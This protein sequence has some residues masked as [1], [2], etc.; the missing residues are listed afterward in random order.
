MYN[1]IK[2]FFDATSCDSWCEKASNIL[3]FYI[4]RYQKRPR[5]HRNPDANFFYVTDI[6]DQ[7]PWLE[8][9]NLYICMYMYFIYINI[10]INIYVLYM[11]AVLTPKIDFPDPKTPISYIRFWLFLRNVKVTYF[12][13]KPACNGLVRVLWEL[14]WT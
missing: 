11:K 13:S 5:W 7:D 14:F 6:L 2:T 10:Y 9:I 8:L 3:Y 4:F 12:I 1:Q